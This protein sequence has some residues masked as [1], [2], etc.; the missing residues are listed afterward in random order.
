MAH[1]AL[2]A[3]FHRRRILCV[4]ACVIVLATVGGCAAQDN[5]GS[6]HGAGL[7][8]ASDDRPVFQRGEA[9]YYAQSF[10]GRETASGETFNPTKLTAAHPSLPF[11]T[12][13]R[14]TNE[15]NQ[16]H[17]TVRVNDRGP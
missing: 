17:V 7:S 6:A 5:V 3:Y 16:R 14:V 15:D 13:I 11:G 8:K 12:L 4:V 10:A 9:S 1:P 2:H